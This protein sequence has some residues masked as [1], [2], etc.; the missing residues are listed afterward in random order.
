MECEMTLNAHPELWQAQQ[1]VQA[2]QVAQ[3]ALAQA[4]IIQLPQRA[5]GQVRMAPHPPAGVQPQLL[6][7]RQPR[8]GLRE[9]QTCQ[10]M[11]LSAAV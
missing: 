5:A 7:G 1:D 3:P 8:E 4:D 2:A 6:Q 10:C 11:H 9:E